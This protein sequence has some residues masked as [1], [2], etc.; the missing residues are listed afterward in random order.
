MTN[1]NN[2]NIK[3]SDLIKKIQ[4]ISEINQNQSINMNKIVDTLSIFI[5]RIS[6][7][8]ESKNES[9]QKL[10]PVNYNN[11]AEM[12]RNINEIFSSSNPISIEKLLLNINDILAKT[13]IPNGRLFQW[14]FQEA[15]K[16]IQDTLELL[17]PEEKNMIYT[18][19]F[20]KGYDALI[21]K[22]QKEYLAEKIAKISRY[23]SANNEITTALSTFI[24]SMDNIVK[25]Y[26]KK[27]HKNPDYKILI[28][29]LYKIDE[30]L[31]L[32]PS[33]ERPTENLLD[34]IKS[35]TE[36]NLNDI[37]FQSALNNLA[38]KIANVQ[39]HLL[40]QH[41]RAKEK[42][43]KIIEQ[44]LYTP[45]EEE[46]KLS[47]AMQKFMH[48]YVERH[49]ATNELMN[50]MYNI[51]KEVKSLEGKNINDKYTK[52][53]INLAKDI[54]ETANSIL[55]DPNIN[56]DKAI[57]KLDALASSYKHKIPEKE[58]LFWKDNKNIANAIEGFIAKLENEIL[59]KTKVNQP[60]EAKSN[61]SKDEDNPPSTPRSGSVISSSTEISS[62]QNLLRLFQMVITKFF[63]R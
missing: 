19:D 14:I 30:I 32:P 61:E 50:A 13:E 18:I 52:N 48:L 27:E 41:L 33:D 63:T 55:S 29:S 21:E 38:E 2:P 59:S 11:L 39:D 57:E 28:Q 40:E 24:N 43:V 25:Y 35:I 54:L 45:S 15:K 62:W 56:T 16:N 6:N 4:R 8:S 10:D 34:E 7:L 12:I 22:M 47:K 5:K 20:K 1:G 44:L 9:L 53:L 58:A 31:N 46:K 26:E 3:Y 37:T 17:S 42:D 60:E 36:K 51:V 23:E 49:I